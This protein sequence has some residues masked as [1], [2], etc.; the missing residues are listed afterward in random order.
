MKK[1]PTSSHTKMSS[2]GFFILGESNLGEILDK[3][4][5][6]EKKGFRF[7]FAIRPSAPI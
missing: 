1:S 7:T 4:I 3:V 2:T 5:I 6:V